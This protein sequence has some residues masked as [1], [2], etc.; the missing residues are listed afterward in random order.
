MAKDRWISTEEGAHLRGRRVRNTAPEI[1]LRRVLHRQ[2]FRFR[3]HRKVTRRCT[4]DF[5]LPRFRVAVFVDGC[6]WHG[7]PVHG[8]KTFRGPNATLWEEKI[9]A[10]RSRD[11][12]ST[13]AAEDS[14]WVVV[15]VWECEVRRDPDSAAGRVAAEC[16]VSRTEVRPA[17]PN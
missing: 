3:L 7:C 6:Y 5:V 10:N 1:A 11:R 13:R 15:R 12:R 17:S 4:P 8:P 14:G 16:G 2:G 9:E